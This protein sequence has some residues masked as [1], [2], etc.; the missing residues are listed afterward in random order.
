ME[1]DV[2]FRLY[3]MNRRAKKLNDKMAIQGRVRRLFHTSENVVIISLMA[4]L[5]DWPTGKCSD[6]KR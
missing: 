4:K 1:L 6:D 2:M 3:I 5:R